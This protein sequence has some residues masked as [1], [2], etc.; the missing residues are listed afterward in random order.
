MKCLV[1]KNINL[2][3]EIDLYSWPLS[4]MQKYG[5]LKVSENAPLNLV[6][7]LRTFIIVINLNTLQAPQ[8]QKIKCSSIYT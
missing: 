7:L 2:Y 5:I 8:N 1:L 3:L 6:K 4:Q